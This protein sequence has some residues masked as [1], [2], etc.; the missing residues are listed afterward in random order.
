[1]DHSSDISPSPRYVLMTTSP[2]VLCVT[3]V[4]FNDLFA[5]PTLF[6][7]FF[8]GL[9]PISTIHEPCYHHRYVNGIRPSFNCRGFNYWVLC[10]VV[11]YILCQ[12][13]DARVIDLPTDAPTLISKLNIEQFCNHRLLQREFVILYTPV[14]Y[15]KLFFFFFNNH[16]GK[17]DF[18]IIIKSNAHSAS[19]PAPSRN[20]QPWLRSP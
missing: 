18:L 15:T 7:F 8:L 19:H 13:E 1:M 3:G 2:Q 12:Y 5:Y 9:V 4:C 16:P 10:T 20:P 17:T 11:I 6:R 14:K